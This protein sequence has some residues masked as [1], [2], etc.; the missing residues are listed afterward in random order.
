MKL[1]LGLCEEGVGLDEDE[2]DLDASVTP[3][4]RRAWVD[5]QQ[6]KY[7]AARASAGTLASAAGADD[8]VCRAM[9]EQ[10][11]AK[12]IAAL[13]ESE[14]PEL[15]HRALVWITEMVTASE[16][17][18]LR[19]QCAV[20]LVEGGVVGAIS[21]VLRMGDMQLGG[22]AREAAQALSNAVGKNSGA[23]TTAVAT[24]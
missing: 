13:L 22:L 20:H 9:C 14:K 24:R 19:A 2:A 17:A 1:W 18:S 21:V 15:V 4:A 6:Q 10:D 12:T 3:E 8:D 7:L 23:E 5:E 11:C 16:D